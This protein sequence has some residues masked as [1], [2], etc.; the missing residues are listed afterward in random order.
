MTETR[1]REDPQV[2]QVDQRL[3]PRHDA[4]QRLLTP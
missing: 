2:P 1:G 4:R 3:Q